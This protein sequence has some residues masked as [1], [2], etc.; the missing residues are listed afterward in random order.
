LQAG[1][2]DLADVLDALLGDTQV[3]DGDGSTLRV[4]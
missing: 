4:A 1:R 2:V 3:D